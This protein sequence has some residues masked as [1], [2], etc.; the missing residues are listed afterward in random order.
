MREKEKQVNLADRKTIKQVFFPYSCCDPRPSKPPV[1]HFASYPYQ[2]EL[3]TRPIEP[4]SPYLIAVVVV[5]YLTVTIC[6]CYLTLDMV[7]CFFNVYNNDLHVIRQLYKLFKSKYTAVRVS[8][9]QFMAYNYMGKL[10][11]GAFVK[12]GRRK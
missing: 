10:V 4:Y 9:S 12:E 5:V 1:A 11:N 2:T 7:D 6:P 3:V 8:P